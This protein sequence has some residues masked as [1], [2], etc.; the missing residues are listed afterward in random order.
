MTTPTFSPERQ[1]RRVFATIE[2]D[3][4]RG[5]GV[6]TCMAPVSYRY[7]DCGG[8]GTAAVADDSHDSARSRGAGFSLARQPFRWFLARATG[9]ELLPR[10]A[11]LALSRSPASPLVCGSLLQALTREGAGGA[12]LP[13]D[14]LLALG[15]ASSCV[16]S[17]RPPVTIGLDVDLNPDHDLDHVRAVE[18]T[19]LQRHWALRRAA[20]SPASGNFACLEEEVPYVVGVEVYFGEGPE[21]DDDDAET[22]VAVL[23]DFVLPRGS[24]TRQTAEELRSLL[25][26]PYRRL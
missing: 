10:N 18:A 14:S 21:D 5:A 25:D 12:F 19:L 4:F 20:A 17:S 6:L 7:G 8:G 16:L 23:R 15:V 11:P 3:I 13:L 2:R 1:R 22:W 26:A 9:L 24:R